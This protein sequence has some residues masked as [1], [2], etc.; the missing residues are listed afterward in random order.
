M[1]KLLKFSNSGFTLIELLL[2]ITII[3]IV[4]GVAAV[5]YTTILRNGRN[6]QR[7]S[8]LKKISQALEAF[9][10]DNKY[11][12]SDTDFVGCLTGSSCT[13]INGKPSTN[14]YLQSIPADPQG[15]S[16]DYQYLPNKDSTFPGVDWQG[17]SLTALKYEPVPS[18][19]TILGPTH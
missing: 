10:S 18:P 9:Y 7:K 6:S 14:V 12:P 16:S 1:K 13:L 4:I 17:Y 8:D 15:S 2:V 3:V 11:Y 5:S 19:Y